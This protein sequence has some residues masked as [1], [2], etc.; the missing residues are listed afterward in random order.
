M[1]ACQRAMQISH[2]H[3]PTRPRASTGNMLLK[4]KSDSMSLSLHEA[5]VYAR[6][7]LACMNKL[8]LNFEISNL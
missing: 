3:I 8:K 4:R 1:P 7:V 6:V 5:H 2:L